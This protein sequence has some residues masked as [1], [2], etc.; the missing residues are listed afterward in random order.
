M[1]SEACIVFFWRKGAIYLHSTLYKSTKLPNNILIN[2]SHEILK[3]ILLK[4][5][6][7]FENISSNQAVEHIH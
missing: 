6:S 4:N 7:Y 1:L 3:T 5:I 2:K